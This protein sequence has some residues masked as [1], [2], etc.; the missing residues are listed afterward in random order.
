VAIRGLLFD[1]DG[2]ILDTESPSFAGWQRVYREH[3]QELTL[4]Q[5]APIVGTI[6]IDPFEPLEE[7]LGGPLE[8]DAIDA[9]RNAHELTLIEL[10]ELRPGILDYLGE[11]RQR[12]L[13][14]AV[15]SSS[16]RRWVHGHL[17]RLERTA[18]FDAIVTADHDRER[19]KPRPTLYLEAL[20][21]LGLAADEAVAF[22]DSPN[23]VRAARAAGIFTVAVP[24]GVTAMLGLDEA[25]LVV[26]SLAELPFDELLTAAEGS[27]RR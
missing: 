19:A 7:L 13:R 2:L 23:G 15:V 20:E 9:R 14:T 25:D 16:S 18:D 12:G 26:P 17:E 1:F 11:A 4:E 6:G 22:E 5:W 24:N 27:G 10:E 8:R 3:G 21:L